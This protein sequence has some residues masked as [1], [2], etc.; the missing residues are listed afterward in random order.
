[1]LTSIQNF[2]CSLLGFEDFT[3][4]ANLFVRL[5]EKLRNYSQAIA[6]TVGIIILF[7]L[8]CLELDQHKKLALRIFIKF[9]KLLVCS[10]WPD[11]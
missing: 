3:I 8:R 7:T 1:M 9:N 11:T 10:D 4:N 2:S 5:E 6:V